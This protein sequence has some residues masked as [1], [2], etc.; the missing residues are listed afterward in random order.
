MT[1]G[2]RLVRFMAKP[3][4]QRTWKD[5]RLTSGRRTRVS[6]PSQPPPT[7]LG[8]IGNFC[9]SLVLESLQRVLEPLRMAKS[10]DRGERFVMWSTHHLFDAEGL[11]ERPARAFA[12]SSCAIDMRRKRDRLVH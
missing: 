11:P 9:T 3:T 7:L 5:Q 12:R 1:K 10:S 8:R 2:A 4:A 6:Q